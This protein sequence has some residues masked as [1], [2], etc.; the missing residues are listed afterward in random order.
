MQ[1]SIFMGR[2][3]AK[4]HDWARFGSGW[5]FARGRWPGPIGELEWA[6]PFGERLTLDGSDRRKAPGV[7]RGALP[8]P[9]RP[10]RPK[11][12]GIA[13]RGENVPGDRPGCRRGHR[14][15]GGAALLGTV[16]A[17]EWGHF[18]V[19]PILVELRRSRRAWSHRPPHSDW[20]R[21]ALE[22]MR[23][24]GGSGNLSRDFPGAEGPAWSRF[25]WIARRWD[26]R[27]SVRGVRRSGPSTM[28]RDRLG[29]RV[30]KG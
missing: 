15:G 8:G 2:G 13:I 25:T 6:V 29:R 30:G 1:A 5:N 21:K 4:P 28:S 20:W 23:K 27:G 12:P 17:L 14:L 16:P 3:E 9:D 19:P 24:R 10:G 26:C 18:G 7:G 11:A 22:R